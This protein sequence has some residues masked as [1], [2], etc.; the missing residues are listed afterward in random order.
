MRLI[1]MEVFPA[2]HFSSPFFNRMGLFKSH[3]C[4]Y[5]IRNWQFSPRA[6]FNANRVLEQAHLKGYFETAGIRHAV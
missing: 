4:L 5:D 2:G 3:K 6:C 1:L